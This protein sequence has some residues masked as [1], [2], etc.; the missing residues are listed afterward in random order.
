[1]P[2]YLYT[3]RNGGHE[4]LA[5]HKGDEWGGVDEPDSSHYTSDTTCS[6]SEVSCNNT[7]RISNSFPEA[8]WVPPDTLEALV[9]DK[10]ILPEEHLKVGKGALSVMNWGLC[11]IKPD[12]KEMGLIRGIEGCLDKSGLTIVDKIPDIDLTIEHLDGIWP[13]PP[14]VDKNQ[15]PT[16]WWRATVDYMTSGPV[17]VIVAE[18]G[19]A[20]RKINNIKALY[21]AA[22]YGDHYQ[23]DESLPVRERVKSI[24]HASD[25]AQELVGNILTF[26][27]AGDI[28]T[29]IDE[30]GK[31]K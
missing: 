10:T 29:M 30:L 26:W 1:M 15:P 25:C 17:D 28:N 7:T 3:Y 24:I 16:P 21:R 9:G 8:L 4:I 22:T 6:L 12:A 23:L 5:I 20:T 2:E 19:N 11:I 14:S 18:G 31:R 13:A 27:S